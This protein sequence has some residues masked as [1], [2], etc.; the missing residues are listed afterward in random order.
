MGLRRRSLRLQAK[1]VAKGLKFAVRPAPQTIPVFV[2][3]Q[4]RSGSGMLMTVFD[5][6]DDCRVYEEGDR[7]VFVKHRYRP[8]CR[9]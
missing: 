5:W 3:G 8:R 2:F 9:P 4:Q 7:R 6:D 1:R